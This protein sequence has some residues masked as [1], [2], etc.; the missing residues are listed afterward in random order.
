MIKLGTKEPT[1]TQGTYIHVHVPHIH[2]S[3]RE[4]AP[5]S[6]TFGRWSCVLCYHNYCSVGTLTLVTCWQLTNYCHLL[7]SPTSKTTRPQNLLSFTW[8]PCTHTNPHTCIQLHTTIIEIET[9]TTKSRFSPTNLSQYHS[10][11]SWSGHQ[12]T[13]PLDETWWETVQWSG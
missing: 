9:I 12:D 7:D 13:H 6:Y 5:A 10:C 2:P 4:M 1:P 3:L 8:I 11:G